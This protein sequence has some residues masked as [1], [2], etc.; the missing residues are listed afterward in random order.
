MEPMFLKRGGKKVGRLGDGHTY[1]VI[2]LILASYWFL[3]WLISDLQL[4]K[5]IARSKIF[6]IANVKDA[7]KK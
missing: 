5:I 4:T 3:I 1:L 7:Y 2:S 6:K